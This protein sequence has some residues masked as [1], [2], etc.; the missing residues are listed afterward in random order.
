MI[1]HEA[2]LVPLGVY[3]SDPALEGVYE[4]VDI[5][6]QDVGND[7]PFQMTPQAFDQVQ[8]GAVRRKPI[9]LN[10]LPMT[11]QPVLHG[12]GMMIPR[13][14]THETNFPPRV[15]TNQHGQEREEV[16]PALGVGDRPRDLSRG[17]V[18]RAI[19]HLL[20]VLAWRGNT[21][22]VPDPRPHPR[23]QRVRVD[24]GFVL[25]DERFGRVFAKRFF[26]KPESSFFAS[27]WAFSSR[28]PLS[29]CL[30]RCTENRS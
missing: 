7:C 1:E 6:E 27:A 16:E 5:R 2:H 17:V 24:F 23:Q 22:L 3:G 26:F 9:D 30:G 29:V 8:I 15:S 10:P 11:V 14:V 21:W 28:L 13:V 12:A 4:V 25:E 18:H 19:H 20:L